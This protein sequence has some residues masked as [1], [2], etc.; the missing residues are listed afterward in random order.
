MS[1]YVVAAR[2]RKHPGQ[3]GKKPALTRGK[4]S[5]ILAVVHLNFLSLAKGVPLKVLLTALISL[6]LL[7]AAEAQEKMA[8][9]GYLGWKDAGPYH[10][11]TLKGFLAGLRDEGYVEGK[12]LV[13]ERRSADDDPERFKILARELAAAKVDVFFA[14]ATPMAT[15]A[16]RADRNTPIVIATILDPVELEFVKSLAR[17]GTRVTG[18]TTM[19]NELTAKRLQLL[20][21]TVPGL[22]K[23]GIVVDEAMRDACKQEVDTMNAAAKKLGLGLV[24]VHVQGRDAID[25]GFRKLTAAGAQAVMTTVTSTRNGLEKEYAD[26]ALK[27][28]LPSM[29]EMDYGP[30]LGGL[31]S[32][33]PDIS[34]VFRRAGHYVGRILKGGRPAE[35]PME[36]PRQFR[37]IV[38]LK[39]AKALGVT[40]PQAVLLR[41]DEVIQ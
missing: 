36:E 7:G 38:N 34:D 12:N 31:I 20:M 1:V 23:V 5:R 4:L 37:M 25:D 41:A 9:V 33:G 30:S 11:A 13:L 39:T 29:H 24:Y 3:E 40:I 6:A 8:R 2:T 15:A 26:A 28:R 18:V 17:P 10:E 22:K 27:Y 14:P 16:W 32:Y 19:N 35:M 21:E